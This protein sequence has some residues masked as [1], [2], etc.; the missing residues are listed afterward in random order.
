MADLST[1][2]Q[3]QMEEYERRLRTEADAGSK[4]EKQLEAEHEAALDALRR[5]HETEAEMM[6]RDLEEKLRRMKEVRFE[7][8]QM[9]D[10]A[11]TYMNRNMKEVSCSH[12]YE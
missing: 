4:R 7:K 6:R 2:K 3:K 9:K 5:K 10:A 1:E 8:K 12:I 11:P